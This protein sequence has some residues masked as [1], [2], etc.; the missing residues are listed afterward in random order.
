M[1]RFGVVSV[2]CLVMGEGGGNVTPFR[3]RRVDFL[4]ATFPRLFVV[5]VVPRRR[6]VK[7][8]DTEIAWGFFLNFE[9]TG[10]VVWGVI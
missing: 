8:N 4:A 6:S 9:L 5:P 7:K 2:E 3:Q 1:V 10:R